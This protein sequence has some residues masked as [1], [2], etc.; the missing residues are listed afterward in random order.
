MTFLFKKLW[1]IIERLDS[2]SYM[3]YL[4]IYWPLW[5]K[6]AAYAPYAATAGDALADAV[7]FTVRTKLQ[8][9]SNRVILPKRKS[10][11][12]WAVGP[13]VKLLWPDTIYKIWT[14][15]SKL[16]GIRF[17][18][19]YGHTCRSTCLQCISQRFALSWKLFERCI[20]RNIFLSFIYGYKSQ[21]PVKKIRTT[22]FC[23][24]NMTEY[25]EI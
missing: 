4:H 7:A 8:E 2:K 18:Q 3:T 20:P 25:I 10:D 6:P 16:I 23:L 24:W 15:W 12:N 5:L 22:E 13:E 21:L 17:G 9:L 19:R 1:I 11:I 14:N